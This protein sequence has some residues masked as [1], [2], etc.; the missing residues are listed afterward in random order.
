[1]SRHKKSGDENRNALIHGVYSRDAILPWESRDEFEKLHADLCIEFSPHGRMERD[2]VLDL[3]HLR[4]QKQRVRRMW[5]VSAH[6][7]PFVID[8]VR[9]GKRSWSGIRQ[10]LREEAKDYRSLTRPMRRLYTQLTE[11]AQ[12]LN[13]K[14]RKETRKETL[15][16]VDLQLKSI[17]SLMSDHLLPLIRELELGPNAEH[18]LDK[19]YSPSYLE[20]I[21]RLEALIDAR[22]DKVLGRLANLK[23]YKRLE[24]E[25]VA[26]PRKNMLNLEPE[27]SATP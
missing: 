15:E 11:Q 13:S 17:V 12:E 9:S 16:G 21:L 20:P 6:N 25:C 14:F 7:D 4:W 2:T 18:T 19:A 3:A 1:M 26:L 10:Y 8:L 22:I 24:S 23:A 27:R 5:H